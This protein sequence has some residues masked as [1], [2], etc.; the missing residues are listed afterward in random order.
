MEFDGDAGALEWSVEFGSATGV[1]GT[2]PVDTT[3]DL[4]TCGFSP[5][6]IYQRV[7]DVWQ[8]GIA[9]PGA[10]NFTE[11][12]AFDSAGDIWIIGDSPD[13]VYQRVSDVWQTGIAGPTGQSGL[14][15]IV[16]DATGNMWVCGISPNEVYQRIS[17]VWQTGIAGPTGQ[18]SLR[19]IA[20]DATGNMWVVG[21]S[22][23]AIYQ[24][25][26][27]VWQTGIDGPTGQS[28]VQGI[29]FDSAGDL[30]L[31]GANPDAVYQ[32]TGGV[33]Q[34]AI[35]GP[36]GQ[37]F[38]TGL[39]FE[40]ASVPD[41]TAFFGNAGSIE[42]SSSFGT[43]TGGTVQPDTVPSFADNQGDD[44]SWFTDVAITAITIPRANGIPNPNYTNVGSLPAGISFVL[45]TS[46]AD[47]SITGTPTAV[48][49]GTIRIRATNSQGSDDWTVDYTIANLLALSDSDDTGLSVVAKALLVASAAGTSGSIFYADSDRAGT[50][51]VLDGEAWAW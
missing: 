6:A 12:I 2:Q 3:G 39:R 34:T 16:F 10:Q 8:T 23:E 22:P 49:S 25:I 47:G 51:T 15:G 29:A 19:G 11:D 20:F 46:T 42:W 1:A 7:D 18:T 43:A 37:S 33:W 21:A 50:D 45:P 31:A 26:G 17:G 28:S 13:E 36:P 40:P 48:G 44:A 27:G 30:W 38:L 41:V 32:R 24:R 14:R 9:A 4:W 35:P 5:N